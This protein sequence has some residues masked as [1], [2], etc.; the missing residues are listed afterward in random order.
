MVQILNPSPDSIA[1]TDIGG[2]LAKI[3]RF[4]GGLDLHYSVA[5][6]SVFVCDQMPMDSGDG[7]P[8]GM[9]KIAALLHDGHEF[10]INDLSAPMKQALRILGA[11]DALDTIEAGLDHAIYRAFGLPW[12]LPDN[13]RAA[14]KLADRV[15]L[16]TEDRDVRR[17]ARDA[18]RPVRPEPAPERIKPL[19]WDRAEDLF[20]MRARELA[21]IAWLGGGAWER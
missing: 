5:Q 13:W 12:P 15:A 18:K 17:V 11:D 20:L 1:L 10:V 7:Y 14:I 21:G 3:C 4:T 9:L 16:A 8:P 19:P 6:H 2:G